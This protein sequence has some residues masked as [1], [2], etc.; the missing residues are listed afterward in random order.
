MKLI[1]AI[2]FGGKKKTKHKTKP[3]FYFAIL[4]NRDFF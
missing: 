4:C 3:E 1:L 2:Y